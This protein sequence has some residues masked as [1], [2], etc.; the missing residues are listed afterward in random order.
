MGSCFIVFISV[1]LDFLT[2]SNVRV[3]QNISA[4]VV[5]KH[6]RMTSSQGYYSRL[7]T[8][9]HTALEYYYC[10]EKI[11]SHFIEYHFTTKTTNTQIL[12]EMQHEQ[13]FIKIISYQCVVSAHFLP[14][15]VGCLQA[16]E[17]NLRELTYSGTEKGAGK[18]LGFLYYPFK[19]DK[20]VLFHCSVL[21]FSKAC[22]M[23]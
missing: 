13:I 16:L 21:T 12:F 8:P 7:S 11:S 2:L 17:E 4:S 10:V 23:F 20:A 18:L 3:G 9:V 14:T 22:K 1:P 5:Q 6:L 15:M 19:T